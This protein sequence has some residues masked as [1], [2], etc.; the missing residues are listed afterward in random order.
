MTETILPH[1]LPEALNRA[2]D[3][4]KVLSLDC[5]DTLLWRDCHAPSDVFAELPGLAPGQRIVAE[6]NARKAEATLRQRNEVALRAIYDHAMQGADNS[7]RDQAIAHE[8]E[9]EARAC[10]AFE[11][12]VQLMRKAKAAGLKVVIVSDTY[13]DASQLG[14]LIAASAGEE[15]ADLIDR[16][17][18]SSSAGISK[19]QGLLAR[20]LKAMKCRP[21]DVL[22][23][24]DNHKADYEGARSLG[25][26]A[27][28]LDQFSKT[29]IQR[30]RLERACQQIVG[31][32]PQGIRGLMPHRALL[33]RDE[34]RVEHPAEALGYTVLGPAFHAY[35][36]W[37]R[38][39]AEAL[40]K[41][42]GGTVHWLF[43]LRDGHLPFLVHE[44]GGKASSTARV[45]ISR[46]VATAAS[47]T[48][49][50]AYE[51]HVA[52]EHGLNPSTLAR[53]MLLDESEIEAIVGPDETNAQKIEASV[54]LLA[55]L[56]TGR[57]Q[58]T[59]RRRAR[60]FADRLIEH[61]RAAV[62]PQPGDTLMLVDL[63]Y[64]GSAQ[65]RI[66]GLLQDVF[67]VHVA[68]R[69]MLL[70]EMAASGLDKKGLID[71]R[72]FDF[73][74]LEALCGNVAVLEQL[75]TCELGSVVDYTENGEPIRKEPS[76]KGAQSAVRT[77]VQSGV[78][79]FAR[80]ALDPPVIRVSDSNR[81]RAWREGAASALARF[82]FLPQPHE[83]AVVKSFEHDVNMGSERMV[84][85]F[86]PEHAREGMQRRGLFYMLGS[87][88]MF[89]PAEL[90]EEDMSTR[91]ALLV[92]KRFGL[93]LTYDDH[94]QRALEL[95]A[96]YISASDSARTTI[97]AKPTHD[98]YFTAR[99][100]L[101]SAAYGAAMQL[102]TVLDWVEVA[103]VTRSPVKALKGKA[104]NDAKPAP[105]SV[106]LDAMHQ[107]APGIFECSGENALLLVSPGP[108]LEFEEPQMIEIVLR[109]LRM[110]GAAE[111][112]QDASGS[113]ASQAL[114]RL[115]NAA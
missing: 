112:S 16:I 49:R 5:F 42:R 12:T 73:E 14:A 21:Q 4:V 115:G 68:G 37:L 2:L 113:L 44:L 3:G 58:K 46:F 84:A 95:P 91:L 102:G 32:S 39:E 34:P 83:L 1:E 110:R 75:A 114:A 23:I 55:E 17:L 76:V 50:E 71:T 62:D 77:L 60:A 104:S 79:D 24:G 18:V 36:Q 41:G 65:N 99:I 51:R 70:R 20:M 111:T 85:L 94:A 54:R 53:Q 93:G 59:T 19:S 35:E 64:N 25:I 67:G 47:L 8:L 97:V 38:S 106:Q 90:A 87:S 61:V 48:T 78:C 89:L 6:T 43:M 101:P 56:R 52:L 27:L 103:S 98:G 15:I 31:E 80:A 109:P 13:L 82:M 11:P 9:A 92:Q 45:E 72:H 100:P 107:H 29:A 66:D 105:V 69:Y 96:F 81:E 108:D 57:R 88:R 74:F 22:H 40:E 30:L 26:P 63:G 10:F 28:H 33:A 86:D 7:A